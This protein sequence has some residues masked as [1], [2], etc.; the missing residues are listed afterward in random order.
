MDHH[1]VAYYKKLFPKNYDFVIE[2]LNVIWYSIV[3]F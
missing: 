3:K 2:I 1:Q